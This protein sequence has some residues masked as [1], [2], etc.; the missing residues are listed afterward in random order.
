MGINDIIINRFDKKKIELQHLRLK[1][2]LYMVNLNYGI[3]R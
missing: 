1:Y 3:N 2:T